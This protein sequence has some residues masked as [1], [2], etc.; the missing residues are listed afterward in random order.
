MLVQEWCSVIASQV[1]VKL[2]TCGH[3]FYEGDLEPC[4]MGANFVVQNQE[5]VVRFVGT[6]L[7][8]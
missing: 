1:E 7:N 5:F 6:R 4:L 2:S 3:R 8:R